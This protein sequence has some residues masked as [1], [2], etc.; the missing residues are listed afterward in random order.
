MGYK[1]YMQNLSKNNDILNSLL[2]KFGESKAKKIIIETGEKNKIEMIENSFK[3]FIDDLKVYPMLH[4]DCK[5]NEFAYEISNDIKNNKIVIF[6]IEDDL[7]NRNID[8]SI[9]NKIIIPFERFYLS[10]LI[11]FELNGELYNCGGFYVKNMDKERLSITF[12]WS[13]VFKDGWAIQ[14]FIMKKDSIFID[15]PLDIFFNN[16][17]TSTETSK[18]IIQILIKRFKALI[19]NLLYKLENKEYKKYKEYEHGIILHREIEYYCRKSHKRHFWSDSNY[20]KI[21]SM[22]KEQLDNKGYYVDP[23]VYRAGELR[24]N[25]PYRIIG[26]ITEK[27]SKDVICKTFDLINRKHFK[28]EEELL[29]V[30]KKI[31][32]FDI[33]EVHNRRVIKPLELDFYIRNKNIA[34]EYDGEQHFDKD[35]CENVFGSNFEELKKRD[36]KKDIICRDCGICLIRIKYSDKINKKLIKNK[37]LERGI[38][39]L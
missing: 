21:S 5:A 22:S 2:L 6:N 38:T 8:N 14:S 13:R 17:E 37:L 10:T 12:L 29:K 23:L 30:L 32:K 1:D 25:V 3:T 39:W 27:K 34:F 7:Q 16:L 24:V 18:E 36:R 11:Y 9:I 4:E 33:I 26:Q 28:R 20:F 19:I 35:L 15:E 31:F